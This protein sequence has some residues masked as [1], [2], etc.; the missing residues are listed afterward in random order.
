MLQNLFLKL[1][2]QSEVLLSISSLILMPYLQF[3]HG[4]EYESPDVEVESHADGVCCNEHLAGVVGVVE[5]GRHAEL[6]AGREAGWVAIQE[7]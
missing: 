1:P 2:S 7:D 5:L 3:G 4:V 6:G